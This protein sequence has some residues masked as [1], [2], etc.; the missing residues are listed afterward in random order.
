M[1]KNLHKLLLLFV[2][3]ALFTGCSGSDDS[4]ETNNNNNNNNNNNPSND[5]L[6]GEWKYIGEYSDGEYDY[7]TELDDCDRALFS[8]KSNGTGSFRDRY[9]GEPDDVTSFTWEKTGTTI[10]E[11]ISDGITEE[12]DIT[13]FNDDDRIIL[14]SAEFPEYG[15][16][17]YER[18]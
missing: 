1:R 18:Q 8:V 17:I 16:D 13:F 2:V 7:D 5:I 3:T 15:G 6:V 12:Y 11:I 14:A 4:S 9:C 10:Y